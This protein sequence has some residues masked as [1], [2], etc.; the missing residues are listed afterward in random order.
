MDKLKEYIINLLF[1]KMQGKI[2]NRNNN[3][4]YINKIITS[5]MPKM[6]KIGQIRTKSK[7]RANTPLQETVFK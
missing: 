6:H 7:T 3:L 1:R 4:L 5:D 2:R